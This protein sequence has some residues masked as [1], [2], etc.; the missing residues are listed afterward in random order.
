MGIDRREIPCKLGQAWDVFSF[1][2]FE[3]ARWRPPIIPILPNLSF[4]QTARCAFMTSF[5]SSKGRGK[6]GKKKRPFAWGRVMWFSFR[7][8]GTILGSPAAVG[9]REPCGFMPARNR[10]ILS[11][12]PFDFLKILKPRF[13]L[14]RLFPR[15]GILVFTRSL[16]RLFA[17]IGL[18]QLPN[19]R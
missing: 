14:P 3:I 13:I 9:I 4:T 6:Y 7:R 17:G 15:D 19:G 2:L 16:N 10:E 18:H 12:K 11:W 5:F 1:P 8:V